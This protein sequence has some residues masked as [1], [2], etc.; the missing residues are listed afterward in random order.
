[1]LVMH[2]WDA[3]RSPGDRAGRE[4]PRQAQLEPRPTTGLCSPQAAPTEASVRGQTVCLGAEW[5]NPPPTPAQVLLGLHLGSPQGEAPPFQPSPPPQ[6][7][8]LRRGLV[9]GGQ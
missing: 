4:F 7:R 2:E 5:W 1:M 6:R 9:S 3:A 8:G